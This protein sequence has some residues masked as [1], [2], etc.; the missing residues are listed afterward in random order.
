MVPSPAFFLIAVI[1]VRVSASRPS[2]SR[3]ICVS[4]CPQE[5]WLTLFTFYLVL[6]LVGNQLHHTVSK[7]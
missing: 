3:L 1:F 6:R 4:I 7:V 2:T 5:T